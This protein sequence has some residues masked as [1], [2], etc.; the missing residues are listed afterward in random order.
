MSASSHRWPVSVVPVWLLT[1]GGAVVAC[2]LGNRIQ[3]LAVVL[4][5]GVLATFL[6]Q[7]ATRVPAGFVDRARVSITGVVIIVAIAGGIALLLPVAAGG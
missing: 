5:A 1:I 3:S 4:I 7:L 6:A 2:G